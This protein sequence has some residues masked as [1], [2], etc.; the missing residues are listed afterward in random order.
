MKAGS[1]RCRKRRLIEDEDD[2]E[3]PAKAR[4]FWVRHEHFRGMRTFAACG[5]VAR[6]E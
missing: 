6:R 4:L 3:Y 2:D 1:F 5:A